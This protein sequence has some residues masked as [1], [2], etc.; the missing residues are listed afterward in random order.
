MYK[1]II[2]QLESILNII[3]NG[4]NFILG[5]TFQ[6]DKELF[7]D[8]IDLF[9]S[10]YSSIAFAVFATALFLFLP[11]MK[12][13]TKGVNDINYIDYKLAVLFVA[14]ALLTAARLPM[15]KTIH[16]AG[17]FKLT[18]PQ[19]IIETIIN[20]IVSLVGVFFW[21]VYG[22]LLGTVVALL[23]RT[24]DVII[25]SNVKLLH[26]SSLKTYLI[27]LINIIIFLLLQAIFNILF[28]K[29]EINSYWDF[30][31]IGS[32]ALVIALVLSIGMQFIVFSRNRKT[33]KKILIKRS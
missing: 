19:T 17:H 28:S 1:L 11:F 7:K 16:Y 14:I 3:S 30:M 22:V 25:Y 27:Y 5:Q 6:T 29:W 8:G 13:Y 24:N 12:L 20:L 9:E 21:G 2:T 23:Y 32:I 10:L 33:L 26:R 4:F 31:G 18:T 15:L